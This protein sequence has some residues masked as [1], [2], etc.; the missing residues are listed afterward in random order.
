MKKH[1]I[2]PLRADIALLLVTVIWGGTFPVL[3]LLVAALPPDYLVGFR[4]LLA[5]LV[6]TPFVKLGQRKLDVR[7]GFVGV[8]LGL[9]L[10]GGFLSQ[11]IGIQYTT[12]SKAA[13]IT[14]LSV[15]I[16]PILSTLLLR[17]RPG[18]AAILGVVMATM[19]LGLLTLDFQEPWVLHKGDLW[20]LVCALLYAMQIIAVDYYGGSLDA[21]SL[22]W[23]E[24]GTVAVVGLGTAAVRTP[25]PNLNSPGLWGGLLYLAIFATAVAQYL[26]IRVQPYTTPTRVSLVFSLEPV[27]ASIL[28]FLM[29]G[30]RL[31]WINQIGAGF[32]LAGVVVSELGGRRLT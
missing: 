32:M 9:L 29:L 19:G 23:V 24:L 14:A 5:F 16:T 3:K 27:F 18:N 8:G 10:W 30:E 11:T 2:S 12:A 31:P 22:T 6:L 15:V 4:F 21:V 7:T 28:A 20:V 1:H 13:F 17:K 25:M 26:Q